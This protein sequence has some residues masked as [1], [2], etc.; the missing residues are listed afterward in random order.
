[1]LLWYCFSV[2]W[3]IVFGIWLVEWLFGSSRVGVGRRVVWKL[4]LYLWLDCVG[5]GIDFYLDFCCLFFYSWFV[6]L[7]VGCLWCGID[8]WYFLWR[9]GIVGRNRSLC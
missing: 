3:R 8:W 1:M 6:Y 9:L 4:W 5:G 7:L 2:S